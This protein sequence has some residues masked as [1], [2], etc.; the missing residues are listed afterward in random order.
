MGS[1]SRPSTAGRTEAALVIEE[2]RRRYNEHRPH[3]SLGYRTPLRAVQAW[4]GETGRE[5]INPGIGS[6][7]SL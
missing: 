4:R 6:A 3:S 7:L 2:Y 1:A 5:Q